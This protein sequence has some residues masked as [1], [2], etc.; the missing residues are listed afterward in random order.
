MKDVTGSMAKGA[1]WMLL[2]KV[3]DRGMG[4]ISILILARLLVPGDFGLVAMANAI[5]G[6]LQLV[7]AFSFDMALIQNPNAERR[8]FDTV[9]TISVLF[10]AVC[11]LALVALAY[12][13]ARFYEEPRLTAV[14][15]VLALA[16]LIAAFQNVGTVE[17]RKELQFDREFRFMF[18]RRCIIFVATIGLAFLWR[19]Y[20]ALVAGTL[21]G[22]IAVLWLSY[23]W[24]PY[25][26]RFSLAAGSE[27]FS[28]SK[29]M[30]LN[31]TLGFLYH[32][33]ADFIVAKGA[34]TTALGHYTVA[35][36]IAN[37]PS[38]ELAMPINRAVFPGYAKMSA[39][40]HT[41]R[42]GLLNVLSVLAL[43]VI[44][45]AVG[46]ACVAGPVVIL[47]LG[48]Q[49]AATIPVIQVLALHGVLTAIMSCC[50]YVYVALGKPNYATLLVGTHVAVA[51]PMVTY[52]A[53]TWG[54]VGVA[55]TI[56]AAA[57]L[58]L[59]INIVLLRTTLKITLIDLA[60]ILW[61][62]VV[63]A[64]TMAAAVMR[65]SA[66]LGFGPGLG[67]RIVTLTLLVGTGVVTYSAVV[68]ILWIMTKL[69]DG[70]ERYIWSQ[71][72]QRLKALGQRGA[73]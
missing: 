58:V 71:V 34:G 13:A 35:Y 61:R 33:A 15:V 19:D 28:F 1:A 62:P 48:N 32:R 31:N 5:I 67:E 60:R 65:L 21:A 6:A 3:A 64:A 29:W 9:W 41:L 69:P 73:T 47:C 4:V 14:M 54:V 36:E 63:A 51:I 25:R 52:A 49:W 20:W 66:L 22:S 56:L 10:N 39:D 45:A 38:S 11:A 37:L 68:A 40:V 46:L 12:P 30:F 7:G 43:L 24:H 53:F 42:Q 16:T 55:W 70:A 72:I 57:L 23:Q 8:H 44:P 50:N 2:L 59:P 27:L 17:F 26:P 18:A